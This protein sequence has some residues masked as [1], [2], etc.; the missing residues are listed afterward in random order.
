[1]SFLASRTTKPR[2]AAVHIGNMFA[3][4]KIFHNSNKNSFLAQSECFPFL[5]VFNILIEIGKR[6]GLIHLY[7]PEDGGSK[8]PEAI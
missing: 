4:P 3:T 1:V 8:P 2:V 5:T 6:A 7:N